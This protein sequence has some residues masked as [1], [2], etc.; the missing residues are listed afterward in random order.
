MSRKV[1]E[2]D[3]SSSYRGS[4]RGTCREGSYTQDSEKVIDGSGNGAFL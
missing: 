1:L 4:V 3:L 2:L